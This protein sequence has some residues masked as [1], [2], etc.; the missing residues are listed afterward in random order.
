M[1]L[2]YRKTHVVKHFGQGEFEERP[3]SLANVFS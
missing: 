2:Q 3:L 1:S